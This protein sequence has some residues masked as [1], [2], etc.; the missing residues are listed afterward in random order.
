[1]ADPISISSGVLAL[2]ASAL[3]SNEVLYQT[4]AS[5]QS[6]EKTVCELKEE[7]EALNEVLQTLQE[8]A[9]NTDVDFKTLR[10]PLIRFGKACKDFEAVI[11]K[12]TAHSG[13]SQTS[14]RDWAKLRHIGDDI[15]DFRAMLA[16]YKVGFTIAITDANM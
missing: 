3:Q 6:N 10:I 13:G 2:I 5:F 16:T 7:L 15:I 9:S 8:T 1:M 12:S 11:V 4:V 14:F